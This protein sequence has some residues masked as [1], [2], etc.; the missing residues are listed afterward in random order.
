MVGLLITIFFL[1]LRSPGRRRSGQQV[2]RV[3]NYRFDY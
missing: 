1:G 3:I 2:V